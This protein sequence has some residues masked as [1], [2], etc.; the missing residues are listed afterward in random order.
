MT[1]YVPPKGEWETIAP[2]DAGL[3]L[4]GIQ[5]AIAFH[6]AHE[7]AWKRDL[8]QQLEEGNFEPP[9]FNTVIGPVAERGG[10]AGVMLRQGRMVAQW[11]DIHRADFTFSVA[12]S[13]LAM[14]A[15]LLHKDG[16]LPDIDKPIKELVDDGGFSSDQ[17]ALITWR[18]FMEQT[19]EWEGELWGKPDFVDRNRDLNA[20]PGEFGDKGALRPLEAPGTFWEYNDVRVNRFSLSLMRL[21]GRGLPEV[22]KE[23][24]LDQ[25][26]GSDLWR[27]HGYRNSYVDLGKGPVASVPGGTHWGG[28]LQIPTTDLARLGLLALRKGAWADQQVIDAQ[29]YD[30]QEVPCALNP[31]YGLMWWLNTGR[32]LYPAAPEQSVFMLGAGSNMVWVDREL[33][34]VV[35]TRWIDKMSFNGFI[36]KVMQSIDVG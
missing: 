17:N 13:C 5:A 35:V 3:S 8:K 12:K 14:I 2:T 30:R 7:S 18:H 23:R 24:V 4:E 15:G 21:A 26:G 20:N 16:L 6:Q 11:G 33:D 10:P 22:F 29:W 32:K 36:G 27:W 19:S 9:P 25:I 31:L 1:A 34:L 28:G